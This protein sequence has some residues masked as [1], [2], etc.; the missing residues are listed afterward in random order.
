[1][2]SIFYYLVIVLFLISCGVR[3]SSKGY[4]EATTI[5][6]SRLKPLTDKNTV[7]FQVN[8]SIVFEFSKEDLLQTLISSNRLEVRDDS[9]VS[10][11]EKTQG[12]K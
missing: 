4:W 3:S 2:K 1:M 9:I 7:S 5:R 10:F 12:K 11:L 8:D 6:K